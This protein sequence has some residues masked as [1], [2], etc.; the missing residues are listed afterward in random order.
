MKKINIV[1]GGYLLLLMATCISGCYKLQ[2]DYDYKKEELDPHISMTAKE[3][4]LARVNN[5]NDTIFKWMKKGLDYAGIDL[6]EYDK[7]DRT[8]IFLHNSAIRVYDTAKKVSTGGFFYD[9]PP[10]IK[11]A[12][13]NPIKSKLDP[14]Q[15]S[16][17][18]A[19]IWEEYSKETVKNYFLSLIIQGEFG[20][21]NLTITN[22]AVQTLLPPG[23]VAAKSDS[24]L[25]YV[26]TKTIPNPEPTS[27]ASISFDPVNGT[28]FDPEGKMNL[29]VVNNSN[30]PIRINDRTDDRSAG[31]YATNGQIHVFDKTIHPF[32]YS[33]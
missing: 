33:Y 5:G 16:I 21:N 3:Y 24:R 12:L 26:V 29:K 25:G 30:S 11:D 8:F 31:L 17:R 7:P 4:L 10:V 22:K 19:V 15:D 1:Y 23:T 9:Y 2:K 28:G 32:R 14:T 27:D 6:A 20:F 18:P 13:G